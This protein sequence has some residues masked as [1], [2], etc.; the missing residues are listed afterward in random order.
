MKVAT[1]HRIATWLGRPG[2]RNGTHSPVESPTPMSMAVERFDLDLC[3]SYDRQSA[4]RIGRSQLSKACRILAALSSISAVLVGTVSVAQA[5]SV[6]LGASLYSQ[7]GCVGCH[8]VLSTVTN[9]KRVKSASNNRGAIAAVLTSSD[10]VSK[11]MRVYFETHTAP[12]DIQQGR[13][14]LYIGQ[15]VLPELNEGSL[16]LSGCNAGR[17]D[18]HTQAKPGKG[19]APDVGGIVI[20]VQ[21]VKGTATPSEHT[22]D[23]EPG[24]NFGPGGDNFSYTVTNIAGTSPAA[25]VRVTVT[26]QPPTVSLST[27]S[28]A[29][30]QRFGPVT[31]MTTNGPIRSYSGR[32]LPPGLQLDSTT[33]EISGTPTSSGIF[34]VT[35]TATNCLGVGQAKT[36]EFRILPNAA[37]LFPDSLLLLKGTLG[38]FFSAGI[39][40][41]NPPISAFGASGLPPGLVIETINNTTARIVGTPTTSGTFD[42]VVLTATNTIASSNKI[43][44][45]IIYPTAP[46]TISTDPVSLS[47]TLNQPFQ[48]KIVATNPPVETYGGSGLPPGIAVNANTGDITGTPTEPGEFKAKLTAKN[49]AGTT[50]GDFTFVIVAPLPD[51]K[52]IS[53][54][55]KLNE[56][57]TLD[58]APHI[59]GHGVKGVSID[60]SPKHGTVA[61]YGTKVTYTPRKNYFGPDSFAFVAFGTGGT[62]NA[63]TVSVTVEGRPDP[64][65]DPN[66]VGLISAQVDAARRFSRAQISNFQGRL[67]SLHRQSLRVAEADPGGDAKP[68]RSAPS[69]QTSVG[70]RTTGSASVANSIQPMHAN[71]AGDGASNPQLDN[72]SFVSLAGQIIEAPL[73]DI[74]ILPGGLLGTLFNISQ[75][76]TLN[77]SSL[78]TNGGA[79]AS[80]GFWMAGNIGFGDRDASGGQSGIKFKTSGVSAGVDRRYSDKLVL[81]VGLGYARDKTE[82]GTDGTE[83]R[84]RANSLAL[85]GSYQP[86]NKNIFI[87]ALI[88]YGMLD[89]DTERFV[90]PLT[91]VNADPTVKPIKHFARASRD[92][93]QV[94]GSIAAGYQSPRE[95]GFL[96]SPY[97]RLDFSR[98]RLDDVTETGAGQYALTYFKQSITNADLSLGLRAEWEHELKRGVAL[99]YIRLE[100]TRN[101]KGDDRASI[102]YADLINGPRYAVPSA[103]HDRNALTIGAGSA[104][105]LC[106]GANFAIDYQF[107]HSSGQENSQAIQFRLAKE[108]GAPSRPCEVSDGA[109]PPNRHITADA[110]F[111]YDDNVTRARDD[112]GKLADESFSLRATK[113]LDLFKIGRFGLVVSGS[114]GGEAFRRFS[115]LGHVFGEVQGELRYPAYSPTVALFARSAVDHYKSE[116]RRGYNYSAGIVLQHNFTQRGIGVTAQLAHNARYSN[117]SVFDLSDN[118]A[119][120]GISYSLN[121]DFSSGK[122]DM[123]YLSGEYRLGDTVSTERSA[124]ANL[125]IAEVFTRDD[126]FNR[127]D[128]FSYRFNART[129]GLT[130]GYVRPLGSGHLDLSWSYTQSTAT[131]SAFAGTASTRY[132]ANQFKLVYVLHFGTWN[133]MGRFRAY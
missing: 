49:N 99:P 1:N 55:V 23:Y 41:T 113:E 103:F 129:T 45:I 53:M 89:Y 70:P 92:G 110:A 91:E 10:P 85:Y 77:L 43:I 33:G 115:D 124:L 2:I 128:L 29:V 121:K 3:K 14:A 5:Q 104:F 8:D 68:P 118:S 4:R 79:P 94:F 61:V 44:T 40:P 17:I 83:S 75:S 98:T 9:V 131:E 15:Y 120:V 20:S 11:D 34:N 88:G 60:T 18:V 122:T 127:D 36:V 24:L 48:A 51:A 69:G 22:I 123:L 76:R 7:M 62:S 19:G 96:W 16:A 39:I 59:S 97:T 47:G 90:E 35:L 102:A 130:I 73:A 100:Y 81:G 84:A 6:S 132:V 109:A 12:D 65:D 101:L 106:N 95:R 82:I 67:E 50:E 26:G 63:A 125:N 66:V 31:V 108:L 42:G 107:R 105:V 56:P 46:P 114:L 13:L 111:A 133:R 116:L 93:R 28:A 21:G 27:Q 72:G 86:P 119:Q 117:S 32:D 37:P 71:S 74:S 25:N 64:S 126:A 80:T 54:T 58:L 78:G 87:D 57:A 38:S 112:E 52:G 30:G